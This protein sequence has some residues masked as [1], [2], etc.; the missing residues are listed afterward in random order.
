MNKTEIKEFKEFL[1]ER[2]ILLMFSTIYRQ[3]HLTVNPPTLEL[4]LERAKSES[5]IPQ[6]FVY[7]K[8]VY[9]K[10]F[11]LSIQDEWNAKTEQKRA[12]RNEADQLEHLGLEIIEVKSR[13]TYQGLPKT[14]CSL[15]LRGGNRL[16]LNIEHS[17]MIAKKLSTHMLLTRSRQT[18]DVVLMFNRSKGIEVKFKPDSSSLQFNNVEL[19]NRLVELLTLDT[20]QEYFLLNIELLEETKDYL[21][22]LLKKQ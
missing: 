11:W 16:T 5:V 7:P 21:L 20:N 15:S 4:Y 2:D 10:E 9:G 17:K 6:A 13:T 19:A 18:T 22:F 1:K 12:A 14:T 3:N 8:T